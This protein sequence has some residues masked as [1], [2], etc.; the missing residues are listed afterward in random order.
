M[1]VLSLLSSVKISGTVLI[2]KKTISFEIIIEFNL[3][4]KSFKFL[5][6]EPRKAFILRIN[7]QQECSNNVSEG[8]ISPVLSEDDTHVVQEVSVAGA[9]NPKSPRIEISVKESFRTKSL[10]KLG[11]YVLNHRRKY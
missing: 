7:D 1:I 9:S 11:I 3:K 6:L 10:R 5:Q 2:A 4:S 8:L